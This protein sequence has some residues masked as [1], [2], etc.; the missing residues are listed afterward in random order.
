MVFE[1]MPTGLWEI[2]RDNEISLTSTQVKTYT[3]MILEG[4]AY[5]HGKDIIHRVY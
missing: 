5:I 1:Y 3:K 4:V 2:I